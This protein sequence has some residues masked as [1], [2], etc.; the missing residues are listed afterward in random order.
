MENLGLQKT[1]N[2]KRFNFSGISLMMLFISGCCSFTLRDPS[3]QTGKASRTAD[4]NKVSLENSPFLIEPSTSLLATEP[5]EVIARCDSLLNS[6]PIELQLA[7]HTNYGKRHVRD[8]K[9]RTLVSK[10]QLIVLHETVVSGPVTIQLFQTP[11]PRD[12]DQGSYHMLIE[13][14][15]SRIQLV[16]D[17]NRAYGAGNSSFGDVSQKLKANSSGS[18]NNIALH[19]SLVSPIDGRGDSLSHSG[20]T[21]AQYRSLAHQILL[22]QA[23]FGIPMSRVTT[24]YAV[25]RSHTRY[26]PRNFRWDRFDSSYQKASKICGLKIYNNRF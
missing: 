14:D 26:D 22:W 10:P 21:N 1:N 24:H 23:S 7:H 8:F 20:Y 11:H 19:I 16:P 3:M 25:D 17:S 6:S 12:E 4:K 9:G 2:L 18:I 15:G 5:P 13:R